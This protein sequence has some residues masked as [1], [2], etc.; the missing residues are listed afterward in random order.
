M[1]RIPDLPPEALSDAQRAVREE[2]VS[3][4]HG[5]IVGPYPAWLQSPELARRARGLSEFI[6]FQSSLPKRLLE[7]AILVTGRHWSAE[8]EFFA[9]ARLARAAGV[10]ESIVQAIAERRRPELADARDAAV[11]DVCS[12]LFETHRLA[13]ATYARAVE[14]LGLPAVVELVA[15]IGY[16]SMVSLTLNAFQVGLPPGE[17][18]PF[19]EAAG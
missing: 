14:A 4:P 5:H 10:E 12:D 2:I 6:R 8:F 15:T 18:S 1:S 3:G 7:I 9:H 16:Y 13:D 17:A 11:Y 19:P